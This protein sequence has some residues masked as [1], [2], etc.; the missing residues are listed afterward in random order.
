MSELSKLKAFV[1]AGD[2]T[3]NAAHDPTAAVKVLVVIASYGGRNDGYLHQLVSEY[4]SMPFAVDIVVLSNIHKK[5]D[6]NVKL[7]V[8]LPSKDS[9][10][11]PFAHKRIFARHMNDYDLFIYSEDDILITQ[12]NIESFLHVSEALSENEVLGFLRFELGASGDVGY[13]EVHGHYHWDTTSVRI[14]G[15]H[16]FASFTNLHSACY[17]LT[18]Q[19]LSRAI[20]S[21]GYLVPPHQEKY[22]LCCTAATDPY[23]Q[24]GFERVIC[25][26]R[27]DDFV[28]HHL[29][30][31]YAGTLGVERVELIRQVE[32]LLRLGRSGHRPLALFETQ[33]NLRNGRFSKSYYE[34]LR[35]DI[36]SAVPSCARSVLSVGC[37][38]GATEKWLAAKD[39]RVVALP[40]DPVIAEASNSAGVEI[41][42]GA[43]AT[44]K[45]KLS[46]ERFDCILFL[47]VLHLVR[48][49]VYILSSFADLLSEGALAIILTP[50]LCRL[51][52]MWKKLCRDACF[53]DVGVF[54]A[55]Y[56]NSGINVPT[57]RTIQHWIRSAGMKPRRISSILPEK[58]STVSRLTCGIIDHCLAS[59]FLAVAERVNTSNSVL[60]ISR[61][62]VYRNMN[63]AETASESTAIV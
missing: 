59:E 29:S 26:S 57:R 36:V 30:N 52:T 58:C 38:S 43:F 40:L 13:P 45:A 32:V 42:D 61:G 49:P 19:Q 14:R 15:D 11:L 63:L 55:S 53:K 39:L 60:S 34:P 3:E 28:V 35:S 46:K 62:P 18:R 31:K 8:G 1:D 9:C 24:C 56:R 17:L 54:P 22:D 27:L 5:V 23:T 6:R 51:P 33:T 2:E 20:R 50:N 47:N 44:A 48:N 10:S 41:V 7:V 21:G 37:G 12:R 4:R 25:I 16:T